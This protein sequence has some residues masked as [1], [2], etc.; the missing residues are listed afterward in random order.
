VLFDQ[1]EPHEVSNDSDDERVVLTTE[2]LLPLPF[3]L[4]LLNRLAQRSYR[5]LPSFR[6]MVE[7]AAEA[8]LAPTVAVSR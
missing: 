1:C 8:A 6:G 4:S 7:R 2:V 5:S 3:P